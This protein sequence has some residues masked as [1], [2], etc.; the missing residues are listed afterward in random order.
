M[1]TV[2]RDFF[3]RDRDGNSKGIIVIELKDIE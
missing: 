1:G 2:F 3:Q